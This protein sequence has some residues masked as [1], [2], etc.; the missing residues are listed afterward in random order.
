MVVVRVLFPINTPDIE[1]L[2]K[3]MLDTTSKYEGLDGLTRKYYVMTEDNRHAGGIYLW[4]S[5][6]K[7]EAWYNDEWTRYMTEAWGEPP[8]VE[9]LDCPIVVDNETNNTTSKVAA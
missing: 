9:Y 1:G 7:A 4:E 6:E 3:K 8:L 2:K 5:R